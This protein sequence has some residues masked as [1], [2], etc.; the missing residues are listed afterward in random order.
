MIAQLIVLLIISVF[1]IAAYWV[2]FG[3]AGKPGWAAIVPVYNG[4]VMA[5]IAGRPSWHGIMLIIP[6]VNIVFAFLIVID[7]AKSFGKSTGFGVGMVLLS[8]V[9]V[10]MLAFGSA[11]YEG[12]V[13]QG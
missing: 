7:I 11:K 2:M 5:E 10:P 12:P 8:V 13:Y 1:V 4:M 6:F 3:K 9:F